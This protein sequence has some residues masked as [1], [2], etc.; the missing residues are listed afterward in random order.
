[1]SAARRAVVDGDKNKD[2]TLDAEEFV[3]QLRESSSLRKAV[4]SALDVDADGKLDAEP[5]EKASA[6]V[7]ADFEEAMA[8]EGADFE[9]EEVDKEQALQEQDEQDARADA[10]DI[11]TRDEIKRNA[12]KIQKAKEREKLEVKERV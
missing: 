8:E 4:F 3:Q 6:M 9:E 10:R 7:H 5:F 1:M 11:I 12:F 2:G